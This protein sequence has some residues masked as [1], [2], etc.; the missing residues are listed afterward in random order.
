L[1]HPRVIRNGRQIGPERLC[2][3]CA[4]RELSVLE[5]EVRHRRDVFDEERARVEEM[6][7]IM[8]RRN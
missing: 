8:Q 6:T 4:D 7:R 3:G 2:P 5:A 1:I